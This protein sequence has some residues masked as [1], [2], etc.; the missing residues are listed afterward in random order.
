MLTNVESHVVDPRFLNVFVVVLPASIWL[1]LL[2]Y[3]H[4]PCCTNFASGASCGVSLFWKNPI[5]LR[6]NRRTSRPEPFWFNMRAFVFS[7]RHSDK[8]F[9]EAYTMGD[10]VNEIISCILRIVLATSWPLVAVRVRQQFLD[11]F[12]PYPLWLSPWRPLRR[13]ADWL[14]R[15]RFETAAR[16]HLFDEEG[17]GEDNF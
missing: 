4:H 14:R 16:E 9:V 12:L 11:L 5:G 7:N 6:P 13:G 3:L 1:L 8:V 2:W 10:G 15:A 17:T